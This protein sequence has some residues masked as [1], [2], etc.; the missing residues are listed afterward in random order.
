LDRIKLLDARMEEPGFP[1]ELITM[2]ATAHS[3][4]D[5]TIF[6]TFHIW[7]QSDAN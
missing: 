3:Q 6:G 7:V 2:R 5:D 1:E 4:P